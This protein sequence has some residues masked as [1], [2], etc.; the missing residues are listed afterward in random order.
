MSGETLALD[1]SA[2]MSCRGFPADR[3]LITV[4]GVVD[5]ITPGGRVRKHLDY[6]LAAGLSVIEP[7]AESVTKVRHFA[8]ETGDIARMSATDISLL[9]LALETRATLVSDDYSIQNTAKAAGIVCMGLS[10]DGI[11]E[12]RKWTIVCSGCRRQ[13]EPGE[14]ECRVCGKGPRTR[15]KNDR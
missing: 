7:S 4:Q 11:T 1:T 8:G 13:M 9:A 15:H 2:I 12:V 6:L 3:A 10:Q 14:K 5:E